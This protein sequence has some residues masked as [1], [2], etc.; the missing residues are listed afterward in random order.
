MD[1]NEHINHIKDIIDSIP[2]HKV[3]IL[4]GGN[5]SGKSFIRKQIVFTVGRA[6]NLSMNEMRHCVKAVSMQT[7]TEQKTEWGALSSAMHDSPWMPTS[8][9]TYQLIK[10]LMDIVIKE[11]EFNN[12][13]VLDEIEIGMSAES[14]AGI[15][16]F[17]N[18][19]FSKIDF[20]KCYGIMVITHSDRVVRTLNHNNFVNIEGLS[21]EEWLNREIVP[22][23]FEKL[24]KESGELMRAIEERLKP[25]KD[26]K[27]Y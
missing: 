9:S 23:D 19:C 16:N 22:T 18:D 21:E 24:D 1:Y 15:V 5:G 4:T 27:D 8:Y 14:I 11:D 12:Y 13:I 10:R 7:R 26:V 20:E 25:V 17:L 3:T 6:F 2:M